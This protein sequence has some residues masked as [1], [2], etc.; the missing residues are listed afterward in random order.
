MD[1]KPNHFL[2]GKNLP[3]F[4]TYL[5]E[6]QDIEIKIVMVNCLYKQALLAKPSQYPAFLQ[7]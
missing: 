4:L 5:E 7:S 3:S 6:I 1:L 2:S